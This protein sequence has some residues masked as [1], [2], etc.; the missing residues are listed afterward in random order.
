M[1]IDQGTVLSG[2][3]GAA[4]LA[5]VSAAPLQAQQVRGV[6]DDEI[7]IGM[8]TDLSGPSVAA[9]VPS[10]NGARMRV[11]EANE[12]GGIHGRK[13]RIVI[14]NNEYSVSKSAQA[15]NKLLNRDQVFLI[16]C[17]LGTPTNNAIL[18]KQL[19]LGVP[20]MFPVSASEQMY[21]PFDRLKF[22]AIA[23]YYGQIRSGLRWFIEKEDSQRVCIFYQDTDYGREIRKGAVD[24]LQAM[25]REL[26]AEAAHKPT[27]LDFSAAVL[28]L[29]EAKCDLIAMGTIVRDTIG[30]MSEI[31]QQEWDVSTV[32]TL[33][34]FVSVVASAG[35]GATEGYHLVTQFDVAYPDTATGD[36]KA[37]IE[38]YQQRFDADPTVWA[39]A[40][41]VFVDLIMKGLENAGRDLTVDSFLAGME[42]IDDYHDLFGGPA[43]SFGPDKRLG[44]ES[45]FLVKVENGRFVRVS[46]E[47]NYKD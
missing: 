47:I 25:G 13:I 44:A 15:G 42:Q 20:N 37:W 21:E 46:D 45:A 1:K 18:P 24:Q 3:A 17:G 10:A 28:K 27:D 19:A 4:L 35:A 8:H 30:I 33:G 26:V 40:T 22:A 39:Q 38:R 7:V 5:L 32:G 31:N 16:C 9:G 34:S 14:E 36:V 23:S 2:L 43:I 12:N 29:R 11:A 41:Y 6:S